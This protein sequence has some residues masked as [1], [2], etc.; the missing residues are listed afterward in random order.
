MNKK[1][2]IL[3][4]LL[5][6]FAISC[7]FQPILKKNTI[8]FKINEIN[9]SGEKR[10]NYILINNLKSL[11]KAK[12]YSKVY[13]LNIV[14][15]KTRE[16]SSKDT[17]GNA[18]TFRLNLIIEIKVYTNKELKTTEIFNKSFNYNNI[19]S[20]FELSQ[21]EEIVINNLLRN[22]T[23]EFLIKLQTF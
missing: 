15:K 4:T 2:N 10:I 23:Q 7:G 8:D 13:D 22:I 5:F 11:N 16:I 6:V 19:D 21:Y 1:F 9:S 17:R 3:Y 12:D 20:K 14:S 18:K